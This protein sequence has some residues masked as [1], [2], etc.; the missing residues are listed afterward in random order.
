MRV[1][2][3]C[4]FSGIVRNAFVVRGHD[5]ISCDLIPSETSGPHHIGDVIP[6]LCEPWDL[7]IAF[8]PCT[9]LSSSGAQYW[10]IKQI[11]GRQSSAISFFMALYNAPALK[12][13]VEN[14]VGIMSRFVKPTQIIQPFMFGDPTTKKTCLWLKGLRP[15]KPTNIVEP[16]YAH[17]TNSKY[18]GPRKDGTRRLNPLPVKFGDGHNRSRF[19]PGIAR[20]MAE[21]WG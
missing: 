2:V 19:H 12:V 14:P 15:L 6:L 5:V 8:P 18:G 3:A 17:G 9:H 7:I 20:A 13:C 1:L 4:E 10:K 16:L 11:D 21:Q